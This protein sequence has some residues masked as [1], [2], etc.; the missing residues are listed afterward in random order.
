MSITRPRCSKGFVPRCDFNSP[1]PPR[2]RMHS[3]EARRVKRVFWCLTVPSC[4]CFRAKQPI[5]VEGKEVER[6]QFLNMRALGYPGEN[7]YIRTC[8]TQYTIKSYFAEY[9]KSAPHCAAPLLVSVF[10]SHNPVL[11]V[12]WSHV[13]TSVHKS[14]STTCRRWQPSPIF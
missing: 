13:K 3:A 9:G 2:T 6:T 5:R 4:G 14:L 7:V 12:L 8:V 11:S 10:V 1:P